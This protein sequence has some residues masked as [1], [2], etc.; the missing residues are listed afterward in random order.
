VLHQPGDSLPH[1]DHFH[2]RIYCPVGDRHAWCVDRAPLRWTKKAY[3][4][5]TRLADAGGVR[6]TI[7]EAL[8]APLPAMLALAFPFRG[9]G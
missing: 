2:V 4:Y 5:R 6:A 8:L 3:K 9:A 1:D 7:G